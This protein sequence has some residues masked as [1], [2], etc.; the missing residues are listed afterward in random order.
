MATASTLGQRASQLK[1]LYGGHKEIHILPFQVDR[2]NLF[3][4]KVEYHV[5]EDFDKPNGNFLSLHFGLT[6]S[7]MAG[8]GAMAVGSGSHPGPSCV[9]VERRYDDENSMAIYTY[10]FEGIAVDHSVKYIEFECEF[11]MTQEPIETHPSFPELNDIFGHY[12]AIN[13]IWPQ[14]ITQ[15]S[16]AVGLQSQQQAG[17]VLNPM[18]GVSSYLSPGLIYRINFTDTDVDSTFMEDVGSIVTP[19][20]F[21]EAFPILQSY[22]TEHTPNRNWLKMAPKV[23]QHGSCIAITEEYMLS[24]YR[25][26]LPAIYNADSL[27]GQTL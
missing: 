15:Q 4:G 3:I 16:A 13:R 12:D 19:R 25:G 18:Y 21:G 9:G 26:W 11:T 6:I 10:T 2:T 7:Q 22:I 24:G 1:S 17:P 23:R 27:K 5:F 14:Y 8:I 20:F